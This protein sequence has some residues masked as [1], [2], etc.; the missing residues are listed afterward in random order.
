MAF[1]RC[2]NQGQYFGKFSVLFKE[3]FHSVIFSFSVNM[4]SLEESGGE[5]SK[6]M[7]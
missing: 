1:L 4:A 7:D 5:E 6:D 2:F 3:V